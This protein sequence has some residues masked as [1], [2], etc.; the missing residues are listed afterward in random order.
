MKVAKE[1][2]LIIRCD[3]DFKL[4][5]K[6]VAINSGLSMTDVVVNAVL[7]FQLNTKKNEKNC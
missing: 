1:E 4:F 5:L 2:I 7:G 3:R 6:K